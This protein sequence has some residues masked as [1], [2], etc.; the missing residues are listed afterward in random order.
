MTKKLYLHDMRSVLKIWWVFAAVFVVF[1]VLAFLCAG[2]LDVGSGELLVPDPARSAVR[3]YAVTGLVFSYIV[4]W[5]FY[6]SSLVVPLAH[7]YRAD[8]TDEAYLTFT[9]PAK[10]SQI[11][12]SEF[13]C[14]ITV[15]LICFIM[16]LAGVSVAVAAMNRQTQMSFQEFCDYV[17]GVMGVNSV[18]EVFTGSADPLFSVVGYLAEEVSLHLSLVFALTLGCCM[19]KKHKF[20]A[21]VGSFLIIR[22]FV[23]ILEPGSTLLGTLTGLFGAEFSVPAEPGDSVL[24]FALSVATH[25][26]LSV[27]LY[28]LSEHYIEKKLDL[29]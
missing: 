6:L 3:S 24:E 15:M 26:A 19:E 5:I 2:A 14:A 11:F 12:A 4:M 25:L 22:A 13:L 7:H 27:I 9:L 18:L 29:E 17:F 20:L 1:A 10:K 16:R 28:V 23:S 8:F 21:S